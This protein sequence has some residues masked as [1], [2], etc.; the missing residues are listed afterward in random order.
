MLVLTVVVVAVEMAVEMAVAVEMALAVA[1]AVAVAMELTFLIRLILENDVASALSC[2][3]EQ[4][5][6][7]LSFSVVEVGAV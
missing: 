7:L 1:M 5:L 2:L 4:V 6:N 3:V